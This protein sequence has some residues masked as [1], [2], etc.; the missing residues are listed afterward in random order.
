[1]PAPSR[2]GNGGARS[3]IVFSVE[4]G[5]LQKLARVLRDEADG[6]ELRKQLSAEL[7]EAARPALT[8]LK[9]AARAIPSHNLP[10]LD[11]IPLRQEI[12]RN[13]RTDVRLTG[14][15]T[16]VRLVSKPTPRARGFRQAARMLN[17]PSFRHRVFGRDVWVEQTGDPG[18][19]DDLVRYHRQPFHDAAMKAVR[20]MAERIARRA[21]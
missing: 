4:Q 17:A 9:A 8:D 7:R 6:K 20:D 15:S 21:R 2:G 12:A 3:P 5:E 13:L 11:G 16:G 14:K 1:M 19:F 10:H 18:W